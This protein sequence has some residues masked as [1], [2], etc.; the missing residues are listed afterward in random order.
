[1]KARVKDWQEHQHYKDRS[2]PW[3]KLH[4]SLLDDY[5]FHCLPVASRAIAPLLWLL[6]SDN[7]GIVNTAPDFLAFRLRMTP[8]EAGAAVK[9]LIQKG[10]LEPVADD[11]A[12]LAP[13]K[14]T[15]CLETETETEAYKEETEKPLSDESDEI[16]AKPPEPD[17]E[18]EFERVWA[19]RPPRKHES[20]RAALKA[21]KAR[22][23]AGAT[24]AEILA[25]VDRYRAYIDSEIRRGNSDR[26][27]KHLATFLGPDGWY[28]LPWEP[29]EPIGPI[30]GTQS[31]DDFWRS[32]HDA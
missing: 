9:P 31:S 11:S 16:P 17:Y 19:A 29:N 15:A 30:T 10:W 32:A 18:E 20:K 22:R 26:F 5:K 4:R 23:R 8:E 13:C 3:I 25:G 28:E 6:A 21:F 14:Q 27:T 7:S 24:F 2:P 1:M 12:A